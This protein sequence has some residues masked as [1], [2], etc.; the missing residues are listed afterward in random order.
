MSISVSRPSGVVTVKP[1]AGAALRASVRREGTHLVDGWGYPVLLVGLVALLVAAV[2]VGVSVGAVS[3]PF[4]EVWRV[5]AR[6]LTR[7][8]VPADDTNDRI[9]WQFRTPR[10]LLAAVVGAGLSVAGT[11]LQALVRNPLADPYVLGVS[12][13]ASLGAVAVIL[14]GR[15]ALLGAGVSLAAFLGAIGTMLA[16]MA[17]GQRSGRFS[18]SRL[19]LAGVAI[20]A[21]L[22][23]ATSY[24]QIKAEPQQL[25]GVMFWLLGTVAGADW[26]DLRTPSVVVIATTGWMLLQ[27]RRLNALLMGE[28]SAVALGVDVNRFRLELI[29]ASSLLTGAAVAVAGG[30]GFIGLMVPHVARMLVGPDHRKVLPISALLGASYLV[31]VDLLARTLERPVELPLGIFTAAIGTPFFIWLMRRNGRLAGG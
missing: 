26:S 7:G 31:L 25:Q 24:L 11:A 1:G 13:G 16:V 28:E 12:S 21:L 8:I 22:S 9:I 30:I 5:I 29:I 4:D 23:S 19:I 2:L 18:P 3:L 15:E 20:G 14:L 17:L 10:V 27:A 6:H